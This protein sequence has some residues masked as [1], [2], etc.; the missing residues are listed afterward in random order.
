MLLYLVRQGVGGCLV[1]ARRDEGCENAA[2]RWGCVC[3]CFE[4]LIEACVRA[5]CAHERTLYGI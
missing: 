5:R 4:D 1:I 2:W 3:A